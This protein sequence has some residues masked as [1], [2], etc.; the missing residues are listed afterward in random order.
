[1]NPCHRLGYFVILFSSITILRDVC[2][3]Y[4]A[5]LNGL[6]FELMAQFIFTSLINFF[7]LYIWGK[8]AFYLILLP[9][10]SFSNYR[11]A[12]LKNNMKNRNWENKIPNACL[13]SLIK[14]KKQESSQWNYAKIFW[15]KLSVC[16]FFFFLT[17]SLVC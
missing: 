11:K 14:R 10:L 7:F 9:S 8:I 17:E 3:N 2:T 1:M 12:L 5:N 6:G 16:C 4:W 13:Q 15:N